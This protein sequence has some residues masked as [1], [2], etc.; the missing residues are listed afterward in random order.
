MGPLGGIWRSYLLGNGAAAK[1]LPP[2]AIFS[3]CSGICCFACP[4]ARIGVF[5]LA[6]ETCLPDIIHAS[7]IPFLS[8]TGCRAKAGRLARPGAWAL[9]ESGSTLVL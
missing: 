2:A 6:V 5:L 9:N 1:I 3:C 8:P 7:G 4:T